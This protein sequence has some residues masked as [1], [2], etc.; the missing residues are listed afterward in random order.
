MNFAFIRSACHTRL[1]IMVRLYRSEFPPSLGPE[2][3]FNANAFGGRY[4][5]LRLN[6]QL[7][8]H[9]AEIVEF[10]SEKSSEFRAANAPQ[11]KAPGGTSFAFISGACRAA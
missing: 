4:S 9:L 7:A 1:K 10:L 11:G 6:V 8:D 2:P 5:S 3:T